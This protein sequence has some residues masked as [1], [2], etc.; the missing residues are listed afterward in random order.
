MVKKLLE[1]IFPKKTDVTVGVDIGSSSVKIVQLRTVSNGG[2]S[3][4]EL[5]SFAIKPFKS[6]DRKDILQGIKEAVEMAKI[7]TDMV[8]TSVSGQAVIVRYIQIP[9]MK[10]EELANAMSFQA[11]K[12]IPFNIE[13]VNYDFQILDTAKEN[14][15]LM[16]VLLV[17]AKKEVVDER[18]EMLQEAGLKTNIIDVDSFSIINSFQLV[19]Q[20][21]KGIIAVLDI[22]ADITSTTILCNNIPY[23]NRDVPLGG[24][25]MTKAIVREFEIS[26][27]EA[28]E[29]KRN[30]QEKYGELINVITPV[31]DSICGEIHMSF[32]YCESQLGS[33]VQK[34]YLT[35]GAAKFKGIDKVLSGIL[36][37]EV[38]VWDPSQILQVNQ[39]LSKD[40]LKTVG[41]LLTVAV[42]LALRD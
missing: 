33:S 3:K 1:K 30:P 35:G 26:A 7:E 9:I 4:K 37:V 23:F 2:E 15:K 11:T 39:S 38:Q 16:R 6:Q 10:K 5:A 12:Y 24:N 28:E 21:N 14:D 34:I 27:P 20:E 36:N 13:E 22:G 40:H 31:L 8:N 42:G 19:S 29:I 18:L 32:N 41:P 25:D 17:A